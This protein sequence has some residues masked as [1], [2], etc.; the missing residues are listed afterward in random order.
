M[1]KRSLATGLLVC[2]LVALA[3]MMGVLVAKHQQPD[4]PPVIAGLLWPQPKTLSSFTLIDQENNI[5]TLADLHGKW[6]LL[7]F[8]FTH[9][10]GPCPTTLAVMKQVREELEQVQDLQF[11]FVTVDP[12]R[13]TSARIKQYLASFHPE[14]IGLGGSTERLSALTEQI[15]LAYFLDQTESKENYL[16]DHS[17]SLFLVDPQGRLV[18]IFSAPHEASSIVDRFDRIRTFID[19]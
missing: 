9:C 4:P 19:G 17:A 16:V 5:F 12:A 13:D 10:P 14:F 18:G 6:S 7:F 8:G 11:V 15:G 3:T 1:S 2:G